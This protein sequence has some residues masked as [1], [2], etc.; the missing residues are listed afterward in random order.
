LSVQRITGEPLIAKRQD[1]TGTPDGDVSMQG[2][3]LGIRV[4]AR[5]LVLQLHE[6]R[7]DRPFGV[8]LDPTANLV[9][10]CLERILPRAIRARP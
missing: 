3:Q 9:P 7:L 6:Y 10:D 8:C 4:L 1:H 2:P 5:I